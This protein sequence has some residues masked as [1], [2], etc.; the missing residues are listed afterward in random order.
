MN[1]SVVLSFS[2]G[3][4]FGIGIG[5]SLSWNKLFTNYIKSFFT[6]DRIKPKVVLTR[7]T[8]LS[9]IPEIPENEN[10]NN[11]DENILMLKSQIIKTLLT[12]CDNISLSLAGKTL[13]SA[14]ITLRLSRILLEDELM[15]SSK[16]IIDKFYQTIN[17]LER[18]WLL[19]GKDGFKNVQV[20]VIEGLGASGKSTLISNFVN[21]NV[22]V[23]N[24]S[25][26]I[27]NLKAEISS[28]KNV[29]SD[30]LLKA[31]DII[32]LYQLAIQAIES[33]EN[34]V[35]IERYYHSYCV[36]NICD[37]IMSD[38]DIDTLDS[39]SLMWPLD[40]PKPTLVIYLSVSTEMRLKRRKI[41]GGTSHTVR[42]IERS[43][44]RDAK[45]LK[46][47]GLIKYND[48]IAVDGSGTPDEVLNNS[49][50][51]CKEYNINLKYPRMTME[52]D[53][54]ISLGVYGAF[55]KYH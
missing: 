28:S 46:I 53:R 39:V 36:Q 8:S 26:D 24:V 14:L 6:F 44:Q 25:T 2:I 54:R 11:N 49:L 29:N 38:S 15:L 34:V 48:I 33:N 16:P 31:I 52:E 47:Y 5:I 30:M 37:N 50:A 20:I 12:S 51:L 1:K 7:K 4:S 41:S 55:D 10:D 3:I 21:N 13:D 23:M 32:S 40:L 17:E 35:I 42:S 18:K 27:T 43:I 22:K 19:I 45:A 9:S